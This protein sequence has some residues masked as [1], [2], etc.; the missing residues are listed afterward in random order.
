MKFLVIS[1]QRELPPIPPEQHME[2][3]IAMI[4]M[5]QQWKKEGKIEATYG[6]A[7]VS[8]GMSI[9][10][11]ESN[12]ELNG[13][14]NSRPLNQYMDSEIYPLITLDESIAGVKQALEIIKAKK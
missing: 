14:L 2:L 8:A 10:E 9:F 13:L 12:A 11:V 5:V 7:G 3:V 6:F 1:R 4:Q